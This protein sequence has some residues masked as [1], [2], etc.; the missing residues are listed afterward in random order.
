MPRAG[1]PQKK[2]LDH[3]RDLGPETMG[4]PPVDG[5][6]PVKRVPIPILE[7]R[8][9]TTASIAASNGVNNCLELLI[10]VGANVNITNNN[11]ISGLHLA[12]YCSNK[13]VKLLTE[14]GADVN[15]IQRNETPLIYASENSRSELVKILL[16]AGADVM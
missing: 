6:K 12:M 3:A 9:L 8:A 11:G 16:K 2:T 1:M 10:E 4:Y 14:T 7:M 15:R 5:H 13:C